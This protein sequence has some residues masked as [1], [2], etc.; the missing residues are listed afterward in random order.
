LTT[1]IAVMTDSTADIP[2][3]LAAQRG[4]YT[5]PMHIVWEGKDMRDR[6]DLDAET[7]YARLTT[8]REL[9][10]T[11]QPSL[12][13]LSEAYE[14]ARAETGAGAV[15]ILTLSAKLS[16]VYNAACQAAKLVD[17]PV[18]VIDSRTGSIAT[19]LAA[20]GLADA[21]DAGIGIEDAVRLARDLVTRTRMIF[22][23]DTLEYLYRSG[24]VSNLQRLLGN[25]LRIKP[26]L[27]T[28]DGRIE[29]LE[30]VRTRQRMLRRLVEVF[31]EVV[32]R[33]RP[34]HVGVLHSMALDDL[35]AFTE[36]IVRRYHPTS[37]VQN[38]VCASIAVHTGPGSLGFA[39][40]Q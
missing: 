18:H 11:S 14:R 27:H 15:F 3:D 40:L 17:F 2:A 26:L 4:I 1:Q 37:L 19:G 5:V 13:E 33:A 23:L 8:A 7:F 12:E 20:L 39:V 22:A 30:Q 34:L 25:A 16:G 28:T 29:L 31:D 24:R 38:T 6:I 21:R 32:D 10:T 9:P 35:Q 36:E